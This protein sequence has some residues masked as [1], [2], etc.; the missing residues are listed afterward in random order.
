MGRFRE[1][2]KCYVDV[3]GWNN[4]PVAYDADV[5]LTL[6]DALQVLPIPEFRVRVSNRKILS[7]IL[8]ELNL[9]H[10]AT[11]IFVIIDHS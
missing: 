3:I 9:Q 8:E 5:I 6:I 2:Y 7:G 10:L 4:L 1:F 11:E